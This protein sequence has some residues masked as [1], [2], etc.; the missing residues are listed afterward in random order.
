MSEWIDVNERL[1]EMD[2]DGVLTIA[3]LVHGPSEI[4]VAQYDTKTTTWYV[5]GDVSS[6]FDPIV[7]HWM[8]LPEPPKGGPRGSHDIQSM[9]AWRDDEGK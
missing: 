2:D 8:P 3:V 7:T 5:T 1:P 6:C 9:S 4:H